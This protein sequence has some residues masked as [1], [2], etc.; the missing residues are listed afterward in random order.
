MFLI[1]KFVCISINKLYIKLGRQSLSQ[2]HYRDGGKARVKWFGTNMYS[3]HKGEIIS[4]VSYFNFHKSSFSQDISLV[5]MRWNIFWSCIF[6]KKK[7]KKLCFHDQFWY[8]H[9]IEIISLEISWCSRKKNVSFSKISSPHC[10]FCLLLQ[11]RQ[12]VHMSLPRQWLGI[13]C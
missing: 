9:S 3:P 1:T 13:N 2:H 8:N 7:R 10:V 5:T 11:Q 6:L 12:I 4:E